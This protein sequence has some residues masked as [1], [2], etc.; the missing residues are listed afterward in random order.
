MVGQALTQFRSN[1]ICEYLGL[2]FYPSSWPF[3]FSPRFTLA[4]LYYFIPLPYVLLCIFRPL[5]CYFLHMVFHSPSSPFIFLRISVFHNSLSL[6]PSAFL[7]S[8]SELTRPF[9]LWHWTLFFYFCTPLYPTR[10]A[11]GTVHVIAIDF[12][13]R[14]EKPAAKTYRRG[15]QT[16]SR[17][18]R[19]NPGPR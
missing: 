18:S 12:Q 3:V 4:L 2:L 14:T 7:P 11:K 6:T 17:E 15:K 16:L 10:L 5:A 1:R 9:T 19:E 13:K 8:P